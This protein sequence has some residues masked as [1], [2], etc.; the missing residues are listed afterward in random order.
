MKSF[1]VRPSTLWVK[2]V[3]FAPPPSQEDIGVMALFLGEF[4]NYIREIQ[5]LAKV[6]EAEPLMQ[7]MFTYHL[8]SGP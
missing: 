5:R 4:T 6:L 2:R 1:A 3:E 8:P 7:V